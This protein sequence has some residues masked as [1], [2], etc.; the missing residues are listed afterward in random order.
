MQVTLN[1]TKKQA[2]LGLGLV[3]L[4]GL[5]VWLFRDKPTSL[6]G[7]P[8]NSGNTKTIEITSDGYN[9]DR[10]EIQQGDTVRFENKDDKPRWPASDPHPSH[11]IY[12]EFDPKKSIQPGDS[13][14]FTFQRE[15]T[16]GFHDHISPHKRGEIIVGKKISS[17]DGEASIQ[18]LLA[19][20][21]KQ[22]QAKIV[23]AMAEKFGPL[24]TL[25]MMQQGNLPYNGETHLLVHEIGNVAYEKYGDDALK[26]CTDAFLSACYH[27]V[28]I[29]QLGDHGFEGVGRMVEKCKAAG[30]LVISQCSHGAGHGFLA[31]QD[32]KVLDALP[33]CDKLHDFDAA[34]PEFNCHD[35]IFM[36]NVFGVHEGKPSPNRMIKKDD[37]YYPCN[38][39]PEKYIPGCYADQ[40]TVMY[41]I[42][43]GD[44]R[45]VA[46]GCDGVPNADHKR[47]CYDNF[48]R[49]IHPISRGQ[50]DQAIGLCKNAT[51][52]WQDQCL[53][54]IVNAE[55]SVG[56]KRSPVSYGMCP[57][58]KDTGKIAECHEVVIAN[59]GTYAQSPSERKELCGL[60]SSASWKAECQ[61][62]YQ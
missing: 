56:G 44:L 42:Y 31:W 5:A 15:G 17:G 20:T 62:R 21:D 18:A 34:I 1:V 40:A 43:G 23:K 7:T 36:E 8:P 32:Y 53:I 45:K 50:A 25:T 26:Y 35:G 55:F 47:V 22:K 29:N 37:P 51:G 19:E 41:E 33:Y 48:A 13:W 11:D 2:I 38:A 39:V 30:P 52:I 24:E 60:I 46:Q 3:V 54:T 61:K 16:F 28:I 10:L 27:G 57:A 49:Q 59:I 4:V 14:E 12:P 58:V 9:P 6:H